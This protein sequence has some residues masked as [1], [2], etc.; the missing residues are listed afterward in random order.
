MESAQSIVVLASSVT[1]P[2]AVTP[3]PVPDKD[4][5]QRCARAAN[6]YTHGHPLPV[7]ACSGAVPWQEQTMRRL[8]TEMGVP[9][10]MI[11]TETRSHSTHENA[12]YGAAVLRAHG[13]GTILLVTEAQDMLRAE[14]CFR[15]EGL[16]V[17][18]YPFALRSL[19]AARD[20]LLPSWKAIERNERTLHEV[21]GLA[22]YWLRGWI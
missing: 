11:W 20:E 14:W 5:Y 21:A 4:T 12:V 19:G 6:L 22:W 1:P 13:I 18:P 17:I 8:L 3:D 10:S 9:E 2:D 15:K 7:L 16:T